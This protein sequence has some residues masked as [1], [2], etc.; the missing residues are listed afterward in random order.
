MAYA[1]D[2][3]IIGRRLEDLKEVFI[4]LVLQTNKMGLEMYEK[5]TQCMY[6]PSKLF[7]ENEC[8]KIGSYNF[9]IV[10]DSTYLGTSKSKNI[11][12][13]GMEK[14]ITDANRAHFALLPLLTSQP[15]YRA[16]EIKFLQH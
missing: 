15:L 16:E 13:P 4:S 1:D 9:E 12:R 2:V 11:L 7:K 3:V 10:E 6:Y 5:K 8:V 14:R